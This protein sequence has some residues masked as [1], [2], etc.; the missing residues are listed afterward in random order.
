MIERR[1]TSAAVR[2]SSEPSVRE[3][4]TTRTAGTL[5][6]LASVFYRPGDPGTEFELGLNVMERI[7]PGAFDEFL[8]SSRDVV[9]LWNHDAN[10]LL[11]RRS[12]RTLRLSVDSVGLRYVI[13]T[14]D[15]T[16]GNDMT[17]LAARGDICGSSFSFV[18]ERVDWQ[19]IG[20]MAIRII[21]QAILVDVS[22][23]TH[24]AYAS[25]TASAG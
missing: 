4:Y 24:P 2:L 7:D 16:T 5:R 6:G 14:P 15:T 25:T 1:T 22:L 23:V 18:A 21:R 13:D 19:D 9:C 17:T 10:H 12:A 8:R 3:A 20:G 11:G